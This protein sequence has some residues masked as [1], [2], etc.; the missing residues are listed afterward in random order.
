[1]AP[2]S[3]FS[4]VPE[5]PRGPGDDLA[6]ANQWAF[7][8]LMFYAATPLPSP[9]APPRYPNPWTMRLAQVH[10]KYGVWRFLFIHLGVA[11]G[12]IQGIRVAPMRPIPDDFIAELKLWTTPFYECNVD[13]DKAERKEYTH[14]D[15]M[16]HLR[17]LGVQKQLFSK[18]PGTQKQLFT[19]FP[20]S[21]VYAGDLILWRNLVQFFVD[22]RIIAP[23]SVQTY[24]N[25][26][27]TRFN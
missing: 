14:H 8:S 12:I 21:Q 7:R 27:K 3:I 15:L 18:F 5:V 22:L 26:I 9:P 19:K 13:T 17:D 11:G 1:M 23:D 24:D 6:P 20:G 10:I 16:Q 2:I 25:K 4:N